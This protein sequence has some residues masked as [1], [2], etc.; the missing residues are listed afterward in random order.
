MNYII[1]LFEFI[2]LVTSI[3]LFIAKTDE[4]PTGPQ[5]SIS[6]NVALLIATVVMIIINLRFICR[7]I[8]CFFTCGDESPDVL[9]AKEAVAKYRRAKAGKDLSPGI[10]GYEDVNLNK[11]NQGD[12]ENTFFGVTDPNEIKEIADRSTKNILAQNL[13]DRN[14]VSKQRIQERANEQQ[15]RLARRG[16]LP[17]QQFKPTGGDLPV[18]GGEAQQGGIRG[19]F[20]GT[21]YKGQVLAKPGEEL[22]PQQQMGQGKGGAY[23]TRDNPFAGLIK[24]NVTIDKKPSN[25]SASTV[26]SSSSGT[27]SSATTL[28]RHLAG[29]V[30]P[31]EAAQIQAEQRNPD[32]DNDPTTEKVDLR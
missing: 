17:E 4:T 15:A 2:C 24:G 26:L 7:G 23:I 27:E 10:F 22:L 30:K 19:L 1:L 28:R 14:K 3:G 20:K 8:T 32:D 29:Y 9:A 25:K 21:E 31:N 18:R 13:E 6:W 5:T 12:E 11:L 16:I